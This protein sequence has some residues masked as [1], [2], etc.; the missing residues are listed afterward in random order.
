[1]VSVIYKLHLV[2]IKKPLEEKMNRIIAQMNQDRFN[3]AQ[4]NELQDVL[5]P[6]SSRRN[7][8]SNNRRVMSFFWV[9]EMQYCEQ[10]GKGN[11]E[12]D[13]QN[14]KIATR[15]KMPCLCHPISQ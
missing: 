15:V 12:G 5:I 6:P 13:C 9:I 2:F 10:G 4:N 1:M 11:I 3:I 8:V 14:K 7:R